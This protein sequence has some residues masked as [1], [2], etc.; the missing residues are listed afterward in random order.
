MAYV[1]FVPFP[2]VPGSQVKCRVRLFVERPP[3]FIICRQ[4]IDE[5]D[6][7]VPMSKIDHF[8]SPPASIWRTLAAQRAQRQWDQEQIRRSREAIEQSRKL[9]AELPGPSASQGS[10][11]GSLPP[12]DGIEDDH[13]VL[14]PLDQGLLERRQ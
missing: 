7:L 10:G 14:L 6:G 5:L 2:G 13:A 8:L 12:R 4:T 3:R 11:A 9:L 1:S